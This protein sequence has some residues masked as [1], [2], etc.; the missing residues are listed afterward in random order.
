MKFKTGLRDSTAIKFALQAKASYN[1]LPVATRNFESFYNE[2]SSLMTEYAT[3]LGQGK[4]N[5]T[6]NANINALNSRQNNSRGG[7]QG[8]GRGRS[9][10]G[11][12]RNSQRGRGRGASR[13][14]NNRYDPFG[15]PPSGNA[16]SQNNTPFVPQAKIYPQREYS[17]LSYHQQQAI[18]QLKASEGWIDQITPPP[19]FHIDNNTGFAVP[20]NA[21]VN[22]F[23]T[24]S[25]GAMGS[26][27]GS[28]N[29][30]PPSF[31]SLPPAPSNNSPV[32]LSNA[33]TSQAG[34]SF[35]RIGSR[36]NNQDSASVSISAVSINGRP[37]TGDVFDANG[38]R[39]N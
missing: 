39:L 21:I 3:L 26:Q 13:F 1:Q 2:F 32:P 27:A 33:D 7:C 20:S 17:M 6:R 36:Q 4:N 11:R 18:G 14:A 35:G 23:R 28:N 15:T 31:I 34:T 22:A 29:T 8:R 37:Y 5:V 9:G 25:I 24:A 12:G 16:F 10:R 30:P 38:N 19:G